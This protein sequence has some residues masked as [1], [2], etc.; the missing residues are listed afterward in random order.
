MAVLASENASLEGWTGAPAPTPRAEEAYAPNVVAAVSQRVEILDRDAVNSRE[1]TPMTGITRGLF[2]LVILAAALLAMVAS[3]TAQEAASGTV[4]F[5]S[6]A[7]GA[8]VGVSRG[9]GTLTLQDGSKHT[10]SVENVKVGTVGISA[11]TATGHVY[12]LKEVRDFEGDYAEAEVGAVVGVGLGGITMKNDKGVVINLQAP[13][14][15]LNFTVGL[16]FMTIK[17]KSHLF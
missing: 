3:G 16:G 14:V 10:F 1:D 11:V 9:D 6:K 13:Q 17:L 4:E 8:G 15:G 7:V 5:T 12:N 2:S